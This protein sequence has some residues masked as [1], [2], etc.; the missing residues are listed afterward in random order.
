MRK[1]LR[2]RPNDQHLKQEVLQAVQ[3][4]MRKELHDEVAQQVQHELAKLSHFKHYVNDSSPVQEKQ[5]LA[6]RAASPLLVESLQG[7]EAPETRGE[8]HEREK[9]ALLKP[10]ETVQTGG[11]PVIVGGSDGSGTRAVV[12]LLQR[13]GVNM[14]I[15][16]RG[17][18]DVHG[19]QLGMGGWPDA[20]NP[21]LHETHGTDYDVTSLSSNLIREESRRL[22]RFLSTMQDRA[23][24]QRTPQ[25]STWGF[26]APISMSLVPFWDIMLPTGFKFVHVLRDGRDLAFSRNQS[27]VQKFYNVTFTDSWARWKHLPPVRAMEV[28]EKWNAGVLSWAHRALD[29]NATLVEYIVVRSEDLID[30]ERAPPVVRALAQFVNSPLSAG[31]A[32]CIGRGPAEFLGS[33]QGDTPHP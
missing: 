5:N 19:E 7:E 16:D 3:Q 6:E 21:V 28:W 8:Q 22:K 26:K 13:L 10:H 17:T 2:D 9:R 25:H 1:E 29:G 4:H 30:P 12:L 14:V 33:H 23:K 18:L 15:E 24:R 20:V 27:P 11:K 31:Q 32:C